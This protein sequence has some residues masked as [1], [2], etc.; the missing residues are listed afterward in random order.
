MALDLAVA[1]A[2]GA[3]AGHRPRRPD[4]ARTR[5]P[6]RRGGGTAP[7]RTG[8]TG[9]PHSIETAPIPGDRK[10]SYDF[11]T[12]EQVIVT[13]PADGTMTD[14]A[15]G[16]T[17]SG[18][19]LNRFRL[20]EGD[21]LSAVVESERE[22]FISRDDWVTRVHTRSRMT[23]DARDFCVVNQLSAFEGP[24]KP[25]A[26]SSPGP[27]PSP[28]PGTRCERPAPRTGVPVHASPQ[29]CQARFVSGQAHPSAPSGE[30]SRPGC[31]HWHP[32][33]RSRVV[34]PPSPPAASRPWS[35]GPNSSPSSGS[36]ASC[37]N[38]R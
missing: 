1:R 15:D 29:R 31:W 17:R 18:K 4:A 38:R 21:P 14:H 20:I 33:S 2:G 32:S 7:V 16:L 10:V 3:G 11:E 13:T 22:E 23:A 27:G 35:S 24:G 30:G 9:P 25:S 5:S 19:D 36:S 6:P 34:A 8:A 26:R 37:T 12:G 28:F